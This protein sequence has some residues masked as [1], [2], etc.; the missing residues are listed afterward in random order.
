MP[1][2]NVA[3]TQPVPVIVAAHGGWGRT[4]KEFRWGLVP[5]WAD[6][7]SFGAKTINARSETAAEKPAFRS[8]IRDRRC[9]I[10]ADGFYEWRQHGSA[11]QPYYVTMQ[12]DQPF[13]FAGLW[14]H[15]GTGEAAIDSCAILTTSA[16]DLMKQLHDRM[17][18]ILAPEDSD[19]WLDP[20]VRET[21]AVAPLLRPFPPERMKLRPVSP[22]VNS[23]RNDGPDLVVPVVPPEP[24]WTQQNLFD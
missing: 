1:R 18:V 11:R 3:T 16:N 8:A 4:M 10:V 23:V 20:N 12:D 13:A 5:S 22:K 14:E 9:L 21:H 19:A 2:N 17:P 7:P 24:E 6:D 15:W